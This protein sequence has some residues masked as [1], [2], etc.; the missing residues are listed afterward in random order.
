MHTLEGEG[1]IAI[2]IG[3]DADLSTGFIT[4]CSA[5]Y[6]GDHLVMDTREDYL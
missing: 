6:E 5:R 3:R 4:I 1:S 2:V